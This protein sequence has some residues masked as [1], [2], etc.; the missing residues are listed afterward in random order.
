MGLGGSRDTG[1]GPSE[2]ENLEPCTEITCAL[3][4]LRAFAGS[5]F[6]FSVK[7]TQRTPFSGILQRDD[8]M[9]PGE[10]LARVQGLL[11]ESSCVTFKHATHR[12]RHGLAAPDV[13]HER[14][15]QLSS[16][17]KALRKA[18]IIRIETWGVVYLYS[19]YIHTCTHV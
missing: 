5:K 12:K 7:P 11:L 16:H 6:G 2:V 14:A 1:R 10:G 8:T 4:G 13:L 9:E 19:G 18:C 3:F 15:L 17:G